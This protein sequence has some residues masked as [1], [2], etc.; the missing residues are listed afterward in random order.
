MKFIPKEILT[1]FFI[2]FQIV[3]NKEPSNGFLKPVKPFISVLNPESLQTYTNSIKVFT[4][5][6]DKY[7]DKDEK[8]KQEFSK[9]VKCM[10]LDEYDLYD[11][12]GL[13][14]N[15]LKEDKGGYNQTLNTTEGEGKINIYYNFCYDLKKIPGCEGYDKNQILGVIENNGT[16]TCVPLANSIN[17]GNKWS[18]WID[19]QDN[20][21][22]I[23]IELNT[24]NS[25]NKVFY[26][27]KCNKDK[28]M[29]FVE[30]KSYYNKDKKTVLYFETKEACVQFDFYILWKFIN[31]YVAFFALF[32]IVFGLI[33]CVF[34]QK[35][36]RITAFLLTLV[37]TIVLVLFFSQYILPSGCAYWKIWIMLVLGAIIGCVLGYFVWK[38]HDKIY[39]FLVGGL[40][41]FLLGEF[42]FNLFGNAIKGNSTLINILFII[43]SIILAI[44]LAYFIRAFIIIIATSFIGSYSLIRGISL[45]AGGFPNE[46]TVIDLKK[47]GE[48]DQLKEL[49]TWRVYLYLAFIVITCILSIYIQIKF[50]KKEKNKE[51]KKKENNDENLELSNKKK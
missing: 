16:S 42:L 34:G 32:L 1:L 5:D 39:A 30:G 9:S 25:D 43:F 19:T 21:T 13:G 17:K 44:I 40:A 6:A 27:L 37:G 38:Y 26:K 49:L 11:I 22:F 36:D 33:N 10:G 15:T 7:A 51:E 45:F 47:E 41:G 29:F 18:T 8:F 20:K 23:R 46:M 31:D 2:C 3:Q 24:E 14:I 28:K 12:S 48:D 50:F 35:F 4:K